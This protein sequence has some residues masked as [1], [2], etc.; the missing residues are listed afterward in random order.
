ML[1]TSECER[2]S[3]LALGAG[4]AAEDEAT[5]VEATDGVSAGA[6]GAGGAIADARACT[7]PAA[8]FYF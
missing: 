8:A 7:A 6:A 5:D 1:I 2:F 3:C 4:A